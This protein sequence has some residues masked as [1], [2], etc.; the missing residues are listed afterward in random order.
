MTVGNF[1][2]AGKIEDLKEAKGEKMK[3]ADLCKAF[4]FSDHLLITKEN[5]LIYSGTNGSVPIQVMLLD[6]KEYHLN[7]SGGF[8]EIEIEG[9]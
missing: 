1:V 2:N 6:I 5:Y 8:L 3:V 7:E 4:D 9:E